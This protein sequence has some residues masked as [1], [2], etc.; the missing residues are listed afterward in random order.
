MQKRAP[1][2][3]N[4]LV[5][6]LFALSCFGLLLF[7]WSSFGGPVPLKSKGYRFTV[8]FQRTMVLSEQSDVR[9][10][11]VDVGHVVKLSLN[12][13]GYTDVL[14]EMDPQYAPIRANTHAILRIKTLL[15]ET[16]IQLVP[17]GQTGPYL[18]E[19][20]QLPPAQVEPNVTLDDILAAFDAKTRRAFAV[21]QQ[22]VA[23]G[24]DGRGEQINSDFAALQPFAEHTNRLLEV[25]ASQ[26]GALRA[27][28]KNTGVVFDALAARDHQL[29]QLSVNGEKTFH[30]AAEAGEAFA[31]AFRELPAFERNSTVALKEIEK[32]AVVANPYFEE[33]RETERQLALTLEAAKPF[34]PEFDGFVTSLGPFSQAGK[35]GLP[36]TK[37]TLDLTVPVLENLTPVLHNFDPFL[38]YTGEYVRELQAFFANIAASTQASVED[39]NFSTTSKTV[40]TPKI[41]YLMTM[42]ALSPESLATYQNKVGTNRSNAYPLEGTYSQLAN[43]LPVFSLNGCG[44]SA[45]AVSG[46]AN[47][48]ITEETIKQLQEFKVANVPGAPND[49]GAP[50]CKQQGP[51]TFNGET[52]SFPHVVYKPKAK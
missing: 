5:I 27:V 28:V 11:G 25:L 47:E 21:W 44:G 9:I 37:T 3:G 13:R 45:P 22:S 41:H 12:K 2:F 20:A 1:T 23:E 40:K 7:L 43:G 24:I 32:L 52:S 8:A 50:A 15:G 30:A 16:Y 38:Q 4:I 18:K 31:Q 51:A 48:T 10:S 36:Y 33:F 19:G 14:V 46:P 34:A 49:V 6:I 35:V 17:Q 29:E 42:A 39:G 26:E